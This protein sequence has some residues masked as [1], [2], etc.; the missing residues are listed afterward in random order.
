MPAI[1]ANAPVSNESSDGW[2]SVA[3]FAFLSGVSERTVRRRCEAGRVRARRETTSRGVVWLIHP[4]EVRPGAATFADGAAIS[5]AS[6]IEAGKQLTGGLSWSGAAKV[7]PQ[8]DTAL[9]DHV[10]EEN[11]FLRGLLEQRDRDAAELRAALR[12]ALDGAPKQLSSGE[13][14]PVERAQEMTET[15]DELSADELLALCRRIHPK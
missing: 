7:R 14:A 15:G 1:Q 2:L 10:L 13:A 6:E 5:A 12:K 8:A 4:D 11:R 3:Q 9:L